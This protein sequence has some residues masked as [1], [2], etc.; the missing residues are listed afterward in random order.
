MNFDVNVDPINYK[1]LWQV[2]SF[3]QKWPTKGY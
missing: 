1:S 3:E 2:K